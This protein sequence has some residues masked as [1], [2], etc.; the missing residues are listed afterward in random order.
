MG[1]CIHTKEGICSKKFGAVSFFIVLV[2]TGGRIELKPTVQYAVRMPVAQMLT[3]KA[4]DCPSRR[5][6]SCLTSRKRLIMS[7]EQQNT[8]FG[9]YL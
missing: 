7:L 3:L 6:D 4:S 9:Y 5:F 1:E 8:I 2:K